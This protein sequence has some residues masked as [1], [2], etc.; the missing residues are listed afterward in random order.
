MTLGVVYLLAGIGIVIAGM[1]QIGR[2]RRR[3]LGSLTIFVGL[4]LILLGYALL[5]GMGG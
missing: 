1:V 2:N 3:V 4:N 5:R